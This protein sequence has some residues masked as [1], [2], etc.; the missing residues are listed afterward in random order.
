MIMVKQLIN[1][2]R[3]RRLALKIGIILGII[4]FTYI[5]LG[6]S[7]MIEHPEKQWEFLWFGP[8][9]ID[10]PISI[11][12]IVIL[13]LCPTITLPLLSY[14]AN[15]LREFIFPLGVH[16]ILG[17]LWFVYLPVLLANIRNRFIK[18][19]NIS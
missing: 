18:K 7:L 16:G 11:I 17:S 14:P 15:Q 19:R 8:M 4:H 13:L 3:S 1:W 9:I 5:M 2:Y 10:F 6:V 12:Q